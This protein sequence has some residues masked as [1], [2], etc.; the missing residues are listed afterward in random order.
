MPR[1]LV[2]RPLKNDREC[3][4]I[5]GNIL[6]KCSRSDSYNTLNHD[7]TYGKALCGRADVPGT[8]RGE[9]MNGFIIIYC[10]ENKTHRLGLTD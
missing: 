5:E 8:R 2:A 1:T 9:A 7:R 6:L 10:T 3:C 4:S